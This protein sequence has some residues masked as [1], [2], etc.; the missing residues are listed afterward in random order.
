[1]A[2]PTRTASVEP[3]LYTA[4]ASDGTATFWVYL[5]EQADLTGAAKIT[6]RAEQGRF[7]YEKLTASAKGSQA[8]L[9]AMLKAA[10]ASHQPYWIANTVKVTGDAALLRGTA[11]RRRRVE[12]QPG[13][14]PAGVAAVR[15]HR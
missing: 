5:R 9:V 6:G 15:G 13:Q 4:L 8:G 11:D 14:R 1:V 7:V 3:A 2:A 10:G 12:H